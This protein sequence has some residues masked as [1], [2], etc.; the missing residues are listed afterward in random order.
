MFFRDLSADILLA[1]LQQGQLQEIAHLL[2]VSCKLSAEYDFCL[3]VCFLYNEKQEEEWIL[4][5][6][7]HT[8][9]IKTSEEGH[10]RTLL[11]LNHPLSGHSWCINSFL[12]LRSQSRRLRWHGARSSN[13]EASKSAGLRDAHTMTMLFPSGH[14]LEL[15]LPRCFTS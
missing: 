4:E 8:F 1:K 12:C 15:L 7:I 13:E 10:V 5:I 2:R 3:F 6:I 11:M 9:F 14:L